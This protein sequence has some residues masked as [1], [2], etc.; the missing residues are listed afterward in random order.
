MHPHSNSFVYVRTPRGGRLLSFTL[1]SFTLG[2]YSPIPSP[3]IFFT[4]LIQ[5]Q[6]T[7]TCAVAGP[8]PMPNP[9]GKLSFSLLT[10]W[11][12][13]P[14]IALMLPKSSLLHLSPLQMRQKD[15]RPLPLLHQHLF[16]QDQAVG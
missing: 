3:W 8:M 9:P 7:L 4:A 5:S 2:P 6:A 15:Q 1:I 10:G 16:L 12:C 11:L 13:L 14:T